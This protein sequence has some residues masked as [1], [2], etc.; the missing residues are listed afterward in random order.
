MRPFFMLVKKGIQSGFPRNRRVLLS[1]LPICGSYK[2]SPL[3]GIGGAGL[4]HAIQPK[5]ILKTAQNQHPKP[6][7]FCTLL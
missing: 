2:L 1:H 4:R 3:W 7:C 5:F 6:A